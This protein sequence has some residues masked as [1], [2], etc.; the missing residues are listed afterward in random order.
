MQEKKKRKFSR[1]ETIAAGIFG[2]VL[3]A[4]LVYAAYIVFTASS[5]VTVA[6]AFT[7]YYQVA[8]S[9]EACSSLSLSNYT[10]ITASST[11]VD[12]GTLYPGEKKKVCILTRNHSTADLP[13]DLVTF[14]VPAELSLKTNL[15]GTPAG[16]AKASSDTYSSIVVTVKND[17]AP[18]DYSFNFRIKRV[19][20]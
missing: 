4:T 15:G 17:A 20:K 8:N 18:A 1:K 10:E 11:T 6:E 2:V 14:G 9:G 16:T 3:L 7:N 12:L 5:Q 13:F 19:N